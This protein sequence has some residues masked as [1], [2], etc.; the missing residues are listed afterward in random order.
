[1][2]MGNDTLRSTTRRFDELPTDLEAT[3]PGPRLAAMLASVDRSRLSDHDVVRLMVARD[4]VVSHLQAERAADICEVTRRNGDDDLTGEFAASEVAAALRL[5]RTAAH[6]EVT[7]AADITERLP[8]V[9]EM[10]GEGRIDVRRSRVLADG[11][12][13][14]DHEAARRV[15]AEV[16][17]RV[18]GLTT[19][20]LRALLR[21]VC[22]VADPE[23]AKSRL[24]V[25]IEDR[26]L[27]LEANPVGSANLLLLD[28][29]PDVAAAA[30]ERIEH[31][32]R[33]LPGG[34]GRTMDQRRA[35]VALDL[36]CGRGA[37]VGRGMVD[38]TVDL[39]TLMGFADI[40]GDLGGWGPVVADIARQVIDRQ[41]DGR[42]QATVIDDNGDPYAVAVRR[43]PTTSQARQVKARH[44]ACVFPGC[45]QPAR[46]TELDHT[47]RHTD[48]GPTLER[49]LTPLCRFHHRAKDRGGWKYR[50]RPNG[51][52]VWTSPAGHRYVT[53][54][55]SP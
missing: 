34:D 28:L 45:R 5:T 36:L 13:H 37:P 20:Q 53:T 2:V 22:L 11:T 14:L 33:T 12:A 55:R 50:R 47:T 27:V 35:D 6:H 52:H 25:A 3:A 19:G 46:D 26:R 42:W 43:R 51:D 15:V 40:P 31:M 4:R 8:R 9:G 48:G 10:L 29:P 16:A 17:D 18:P 7:F 30:R 38:L 24:R 41:T 49:N 21:R 23:D 44:R 39:R 1:M 32:A 54:G